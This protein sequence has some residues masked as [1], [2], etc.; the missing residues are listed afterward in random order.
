MRSTARLLAQARPAS[1]L[2]G[3]VLPLEYFLNRTKALALY[4]SFIRSS[5][6]L[7]DISARQETVRFFRHD[8]E[9]LK[10]VVDPEKAKT[11]LSFAKRQ[12]KQLNSTGMLVGHPGEKWRGTR[13][14]KGE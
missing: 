11:L 2:S 5:R 12:L 3:P 14:A 7:G 9:K 13:V 4:R 10:H 8:F 1:R 6:G